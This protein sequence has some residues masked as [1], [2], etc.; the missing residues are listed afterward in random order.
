MVQLRLS[1]PPALRDTVLPLLY[2]DPAVRNV[3]VLRD[4]ARDPDG[5]AVLA[6]V[7]RER[8]G[9]LLAHLDELGLARS[10]AVSLQELTAAPYAGAV[11][12]E[13][14]APGSPEDGVIWRVVEDQAQAAV[15]PGWGFHA[16][17]WLAVALAAVAVVTDSSI[18]VVGA[19][20]VGPEFS[21]VAAAC[22][23]LALRRPRLAA[24]AAVVLV[25]GF[26]LAVAVVTV[27]AL[28]ARVGGWVTVDDVLAPRPLTGFIWRPDRW[29]LVVALLAGIAGVL[30]TTSGRAS[31]LVGVFIS[32]T[33][34]PAAGNLALGLA[35]WSPAEM[36]GSLAQLGLNLAG[37][38]VAG[39]ATL[40]GQRAYWSAMSSRRTAR[41][42]R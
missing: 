23:G 6:D 33:T 37:M 41:L 17:L 22:V 42:P 28:L 13:R 27:L 40:L 7:A 9:G 36:G 24:R 29:S 11:A 14:A 39:T 8:A 10:G 30:S 2:D 16:F 12:A 31:A 1:V 19:M 26:A 15:R 18:L 34:V 4:A 35:V 20:V 25:T 3:V 5:D 21:L 32:V 38:V